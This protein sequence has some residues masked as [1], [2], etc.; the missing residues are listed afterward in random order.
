VPAEA[1]RRWGVEIALLVVT[2]AAAGGD[3]HVLDVGTVVAHLLSLRKR[4]RVGVDAGGDLSDQPFFPCFP[5]D[6]P[7]A[8]P[9]QQSEARKRK[10]RWPNK[11]CCLEPMQHRQG[12]RFATSIS[13]RRCRQI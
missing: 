2:E 12:S 3:M 1:E 7:G 13:G 5:F 10:E 8:E 6:L 11:L 9:D 4:D